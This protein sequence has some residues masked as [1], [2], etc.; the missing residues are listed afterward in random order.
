M[1]SSTFSILWLFAVITI[2]A[3]AFAC[4]KVHNPA[5]TLACVQAL[6]L[7]AAWKCLH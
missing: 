3:I 2:A 5:F 7:A 4:V 1:T 6:T